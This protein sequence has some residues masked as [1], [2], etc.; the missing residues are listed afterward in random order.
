MAEEGNRVEDIDLALIE[1][2]E[3]FMREPD[4]VQKYVALLRAGKVPP[5]IW[6]H[7]I[8]SAKYRLPRV[9]WHG[10]DHGGEDLGH[11]TIRA[12]ICFDE[13]G[14]AAWQEQLRSLRKTRRR[15]NR[16]RR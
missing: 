14:Y 3:R 10:A 6:V 9:R 2:F 11:K 16:R 15:P 1:P 5:V 13:Y 4:R 8:P 7:E 12:R